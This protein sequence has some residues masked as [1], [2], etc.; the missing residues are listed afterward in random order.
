MKFTFLFLNSAKIQIFIPKSAYGGGV[1]WGGHRFRRK[2]VFLVLSFLALVDE[3][4]THV[5]QVVEGEKGEQENRSPDEGAGA[6]EEENL[7]QILN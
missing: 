3:K 4:H 7:E 5:A 6:L 2:T 1:G